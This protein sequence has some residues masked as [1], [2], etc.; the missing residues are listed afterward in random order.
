MEYQKELERYIENHIDDFSDI[1]IDYAIKLL[2]RVESNP[3]LSDFF[4]TNNISIY[5]F[6]NEALPIS[7]YKLKTIGGEILDENEMNQVFG[8][9]II[10]KEILYLQLMDLITIKDINEYDEIIYEL[11]SDAINHFIKKYNVRLPKYISIRDLSIV[12][13]DINS[14]DDIDLDNDTLRLN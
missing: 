9:V 8:T 12:N 13:T 4:E 7:E 3:F 6:L 1:V 5:S 14:D 11:S 2:D 10:K